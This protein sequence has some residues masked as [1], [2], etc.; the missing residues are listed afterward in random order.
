MN[1]TTDALVN[2][3]SVLHAIKGNWVSLPITER[4]VDR[5]QDES[6]EPG[7]WASRKGGPG[8]G[9]RCGSGE[10]WGRHPPR[11]ADKAGLGMASFG[12]PPLSPVH[13]RLVPGA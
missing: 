12:S 1:G 2:C 11:V 4:L 6:R 10:N 3:L 8:P 5:R 13:Y 7:K 9:S